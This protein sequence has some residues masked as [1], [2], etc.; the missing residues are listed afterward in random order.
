MQIAAFAMN[1]LTEHAA[2]HHVVD[3]EF[4]RHVVDVFHHAEMPTGFLGGL[5]ELPAFLHRV[6]GGNLG[7]GVLA[8]LH[9]GEAHGHMHFPRRGGIDEVQFLLGAHALEVALAA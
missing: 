6:S 1:Q 5:H 7:G 8:I 4:V 2:T 3:D 9:R